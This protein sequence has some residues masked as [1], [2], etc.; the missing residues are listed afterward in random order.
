MNNNR[1][2]NNENRILG[3]MGRFLM[4][5]LVAMV[6]TTVGAP[7]AQAQL[8]DLKKPEPTVPEAFTLQGEFVRMA[9]NNEGFVTLG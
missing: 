1:G 6:I 4:M 5:V 3:I 9:Y 2:E 7:V 8:E